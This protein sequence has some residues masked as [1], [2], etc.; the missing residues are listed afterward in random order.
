MNQSFDIL[1]EDLSL[2]KSVVSDD[3][4]CVSWDETWPMAFFKQPQFV[5]SIRMF[6]TR[7]RFSG[8]TNLRFWFHP[9]DHRIFSELDTGRP[10]N[11]KKH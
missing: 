8:Q 9:W 1:D 10:K 11:L 5:K 6:V 2:V 3:N 7:G 4:G